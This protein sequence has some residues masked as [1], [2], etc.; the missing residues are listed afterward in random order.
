MEEGEASWD[1]LYAKAKWTAFQ[2]SAKRLAGWKEEEKERHVVVGRLP[3]CE[4][5]NKK[6]GLDLERYW[7]TVDGFICILQKKK[8]KKKSVETVSSHTFKECMSRL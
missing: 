7:E 1:A 3:V 8:K 5:E 2:R 6:P 4:E